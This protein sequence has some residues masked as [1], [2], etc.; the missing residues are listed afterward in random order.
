MSECDVLLVLIGPKWLRV[1]DKTGG[2]RLDDP[3]DW[4]HVEVVAALERDIPVIPI[5]IDGTD[6]PNEE[7]LPL[8][9]RGL[10]N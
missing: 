4:V 9:L 5:L 8:P 6:M 3:K 2:R 7:R 1:K 10:A